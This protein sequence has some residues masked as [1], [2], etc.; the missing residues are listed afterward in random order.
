MVNTLT[1]ASNPD[2]RPQSKLKYAYF[3]G[4]VAQGACRELH[5]STTSLAAVLGI[6]LIE[7]KKASCCGS[8]TFKEESQLLEDSVNARNIAWRRNCNCPVDHCST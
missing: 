2:S 6:E 3:P 8:G 5:L 7:L 4:C 1:F